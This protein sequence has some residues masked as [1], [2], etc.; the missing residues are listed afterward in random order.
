MKKLIL[1]SLAACLL[2]GSAATAAKAMTPAQWWAL[3][4]PYA[5]APVMP[6]YAA[7]VTFNPYVPRYPVYTNPYP[8][9]LYHRHYH[10]W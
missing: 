9:Y 5:Y 7:P 1:G 3:H 4:H 6:T 8:A 10:V 2:L